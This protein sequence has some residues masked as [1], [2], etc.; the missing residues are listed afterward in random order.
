MAA[1]SVSVVICTQDRPDAVERCLT[2]IAG[3]ETKPSE[4]VLVDQG[5]ATHDV[6]RA[7]LERAGI[8]FVHLRIGPGGT[9]RSRNAGIEIAE[10]ALVAFTDDDCVPDTGWLKYLVRAVESTGAAGGRVLPLPAADNRLVAVSSRTSTHR[11]RF[12]PDAD[13]FPWDIGTGGNLLVR[14]EYL[15]SIRGF[16]EALG[17][18]TR[19]PAA[20]DIDL[21]DRLLA[22]G[23][24]F[25]YE[26]DAVVLHEMKSRRNRLASRY[27]YGRGMGAFIAAERRTRSRER[28]SLLRAYMRLQITSFRRGLAGLKGWQTIET[29]C[30]LAGFLVGFA[31][32][33][34]AAGRSGR[35]L[36]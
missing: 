2:A 29:A 19:Y 12:E 14:R 21:I 11:A 23:C 22:A 9:S 30:M 18:G 6:G 15:A 26:P 1:R 7:A 35:R 10:G 20:E 17:P 4:V 24:S 34:F 27:P 13:P 8:R 32:W 16:N 33:W 28:P 5:P 3:G 36:A 25:T 31:S